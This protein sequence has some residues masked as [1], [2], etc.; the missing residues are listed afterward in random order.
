M[1][2]AEYCETLRRKY[3]QR[4]RDTWLQEFGYPPDSF[5]TVAIERY[6]RFQQELDNHG[7]RLAEFARMMCAPPT[8]RASVIR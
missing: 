4:V 3:P 2:A 6:P 8:G 5:E 7:K 1:N